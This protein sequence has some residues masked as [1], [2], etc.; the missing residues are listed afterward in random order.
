MSAFKDFLTDQHRIRQS[1]DALMNSYGAIRKDRVYI[2]GRV[3]TEWTDERRHSDSPHYYYYLVANLVKILGKPTSQSKMSTEWITSV[4]HIV[5]NHGIMLSS[6][7]IV[8]DEW[9]R[10]GL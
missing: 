1:L 8:V 6:D 5:A 7:T 2:D 9:W 10:D 3:N 4:Y